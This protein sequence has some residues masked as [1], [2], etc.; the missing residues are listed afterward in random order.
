MCHSIDIWFYA[1]MNDP[2]LLLCRFYFL[3][4]FKL[5]ENQMLWF[6]HLAFFCFFSSIF[7]H[8]MSNVH[9]IYLFFPINATFSFRMIYI[10]VYFI[11][12]FPMIGLTVPIDWKTAILFVTAK[13]IKRNKEND[14]YVN[15]CTS[16]RNPIRMQNIRQNYWIDID[17]HSFIQIRLM[18]DR[19]CHFK[20]N[21]AMTLI[22]QYMLTAEKKVHKHDCVLQNNLMRAYRIFV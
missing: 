4:L 22:N 21:N 9:N 2:F 3:C 13:P 10:W 18:S 7:M 6:W 12:F 1:K 15:W 8:S 17:I 14:K 11:L 16:D 19:T 5:R 20:I